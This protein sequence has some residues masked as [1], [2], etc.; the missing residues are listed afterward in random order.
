MKTAAFID[1]QGTIGGKGTDDITS[2][3]LFPFSGKA[4]RRLNDNDILVIG[5]TNQS[6]ISKGEL[7]WDAYYKKLNFLKKELHLQ[8]ARFD[9]VYCCPHTRNDRCNCKKPLTGMIDSAC[10][11]FDID[12]KN[13]YVIGDMGM[14]D[15]VLANNI[16][17]MGILVLTG[18]GKGSL[19]EYR[20]TWKDVEPYYIAENLYCAVEKI[21]DDIK[22]RETP[23]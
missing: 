18:V 23:V 1:F 22:N 10:S 20:H 11:V 5:I 14:S 4:I 15:M 17:A 16:G 9:A 21:M 2:L 12:L 8:K 3:D 7:S 19:H 6:H 13:S